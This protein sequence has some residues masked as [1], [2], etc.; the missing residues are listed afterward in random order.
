MT[1]YPATVTVA[2][3]WILCCVFFHIVTLAFVAFQFSSTELSLWCINV[4][5]IFFI[6]ATH[7]F[8]LDDQLYNADFFASSQVVSLFLLYFS[9]QCVCCM[10]LL[11]LILSCWL[12]CSP[13]LSAGFVEF[14]WHTL[15][16]FREDT[17]CSFLGW[18][19]IWAHWMNFCVWEC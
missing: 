12:F 6:F 18:S 19:C 4:P 9:K 3:F 10:Y 13:S 2:R 14:S 11:A 15:L 1:V 16:A 17:F 8:L 7:I 5:S